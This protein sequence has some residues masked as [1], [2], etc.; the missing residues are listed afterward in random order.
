[1]NW[2][3]IPKP[4]DLGGIGVKKMSQ[5][6]QALPAKMGWHIHQKDSGLWAWL[7]MKKYLDN[8]SV[9]KAPTHIKAYYSST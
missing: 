4:K 3:T 7:I 6:D 5:V 8:S 1:M 2:D 9:L